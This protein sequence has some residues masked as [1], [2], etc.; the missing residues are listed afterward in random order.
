MMKHPNPS[1]LFAFAY[2]LVGLGMGIF[3]TVTAIG[4]YRF[5]FLYSTL[6]AFITAYVLWK[7]IMEKRTHAFKR[8]ALLTGGLSGILSHYVCW[9]FLY[10]S[11][12]VCYWS[13]GGC[14]D[15]L[16]EAPA[17]LVVA[18]LGAFALS[19]WSLLLFGWVTIIAGIVIAMVMAPYFTKHR[20]EE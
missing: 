15:S 2:A 9:Y 19:F 16:G 20:R 8:F 1:L 3:V 17:N 5:F 14:T 6:A 18:L 11:A 7:L 13:V 10:V 12:N 4:D